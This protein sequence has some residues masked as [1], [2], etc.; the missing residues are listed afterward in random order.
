MNG[1]RRSGRAVGI[2]ILALLLTI[3]AVAFPSQAH[4]GKEGVFVNEQVYFTLEKVRLTTEGDEKLLRFNVALH[5]ESGYTID[6]NGFGVRVVDTDGYS[7]AAKLTRQY[8]ARVLPGKV[9][10]YAY[11]ARLPLITIADDLHV[12]VFAWQSGDASPMRDLGK[13]SVKAAM[14]HAAEQPSV[15]SVPLSQLD[16]QRQTNDSIEYRAIGESVLVTENGWQLFVEMM[17]HTTVSVPA[18]VPDGLQLR[19]SNEAGQT[20]PV[21]VIEGGDKQLL[22]GTP[23]RITARAEVAAADVH[24]RWTLQFVQSN[25]ATVVELDSLEAGQAGV[26]A[27]LGE[28]AVLTDA[29]GRETAVVA[30]DAA[31]VSSVENGQWVSVEV[32]VSNRSQYVSSVPAFAAVVQAKS[33]GVSV[34]AEQIRTSASYVQPGGRESVTFQAFLPSGVTPGDMQFVLLETRGTAAASTG[35]TASG[36]AANGSAGAS[37]SGTGTGNGSSSAANRQVPVLTASL[38]HASA[39]LP[40]LGETYTIGDKL[41]LALQQKMDVAV[42]ELRLYDNDTNGLKTAVAKLKVTN[43]DS[44]VLPSPSFT[45]E[46]VD[47]R[48]N[49]YSGTK[50]AT[51]AAQLATSSSYLI[52]YSFLITEIAEEEPLML[53]FYQESEAGKVPLGAVRTAF[54]L[55][56]VDDDTWSLFPYKVEMRSK[57]LLHGVLSTTFSY[58]LRMD[59]DVERQ[60][61]LLTDANL[62]KLHFELLDGTGQTLSSQTLP[63]IGGTR[64]V[65]GMNEIT[66]TNLRLNQFSSRNYVVVYEAVETPNGTVKR[67]LAE[68]R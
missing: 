67:K 13:L 54:Q 66:F 58:T 37:G 65:N 36:G 23:Q 21:T 56:N 28:S 44:S 57:I 41:P 7:S 34:A 43:T 24:G 33:G 19:L 25:G 46:L 35:N 60:A 63:F 64:I 9:Q 20:V 14:A 61:Q 51:A 32:G 4:A 15:A 12:A 53:R 31:I 11:E 68:I 47:S 45:V 17:A 27:A 50:Q 55:D 18:A 16:V 29:Q 3:A 10:E 38:E 30:V 6:Y 59:L 5:N 40:G 39:S 52:S 49:V 26:V 42:S 8:G 62:S 2:H 48:G 1:L 22:P